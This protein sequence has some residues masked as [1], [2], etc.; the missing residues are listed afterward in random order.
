MINLYGI[1]FVDDNHVEI[2]AAGCIHLE[3]LALNFCT[4]VKGSSFKTLLQRCK[5]LQCLL[6]QNT[7]QDRPVRRQS[8]NAFF[9]VCLGIEDSGIL[10]AEWE[11]SA[12]T[13]IDLSSTELSEA[14][15]IN[16][17]SRMP[18]LTYLA[19]PN[20]DGFTDQVCPEMLSSLDFVGFPGVG[21]AH[22]AEQV[23]QSTRH[24]F[25]SHGEFEFRMR[26]HIFE[27]ARTATARF[28][29]QRQ[30]ENDRTVLDQCNTAFEKYQVKLEAEYQFRRLMIDIDQKRIEIFL[31]LRSNR[32]TMMKSLHLV[33]SPST[34][35]F[36]LAS[37]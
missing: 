2:V 12:L 23:D 36:L 16:V 18:K 19:V 28:V 35:V 1:F 37:P 10:S 31:Q 34:T 33:F 22:R 17:F 9:F 14:C 5:K 11:A 15:L 3:C 32:S 20:C 30:P 27:T 13:E 25:E 8:I 21:V 24:R 29:L 6:L 26:F 4:R 7:G